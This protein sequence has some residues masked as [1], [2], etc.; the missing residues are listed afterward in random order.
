M[1]RLWVIFFVVTVLQA[2]QT[3]LSLIDKAYHSGKITKTEWLEYR[4]LVLLNPEKLP[5]EFKGEPEPCATDILVTHWRETGGK[6]LR[7]RPTLSGPEET[8]ETEHF[9]IHYTLSGDDATSTYYANSVSNYAEYCWS[10][11]VDSLGWDAPPS[12]Y[13]YGGDNRYDIYIINLPYGVLGYTQPEYAGPDPTQ[14]DM[15]SYI[16]I[17]NNIGSTGQLE[18]TVAHEFN[19]A[20][21]FSYSGNEDT[22]WMENCAVWMEDVVYDNVNDYIGYLE[23]SSPNPLASPRYAISTT[24]D[25]YEYA[26]GIWPMFLAEFY[27]T[28]DVPRK[29]WERMGTHVGD[30][31]FSDMDYVLNN[32]YSSNLKEALKY[33]ALW[34]YFTGSR[35]DDY[36][37]EEA[38]LW[39]T[40]HLLRYHNSYPASGDEGN[41]PPQSR[42]GTAYVDFN[43]GSGDL[44]IDFDGQDYYP[45]AWACFAVGYVSGGPSDEFEMTLDEDHAT[46][47]DTLSFADYDHITLI[48]VVKFWFSY[49][50]GLSFTYNADIDHGDINVFPQP[51]DVYNTD[52]GYFYVSNEGNGMLNVTDIYPAINWITG[53]DPSSFSL[54]PGDTQLVTFTMDTTGLDTLNYGYIVIASD[55][56]D[57]SNIL[58]T[59]VLHLTPY[60][61]GDIN[62]DGQITSGDLTYLSSYLFAGGPPP[63]SEWAADVNGDGSIT[64]GD[65]NYLAN[66]LFAGGPEPNCP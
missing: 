36:H 48:P 37:Y 28:V 50:S 29:M 52:T 44:H 6:I 1:K 54:S 66:Y 13:G 30:F 62:G 63:V 22:W 59:V 17:D 3:S 9:I 64:S 58:L 49:A 19:H 39:P 33:Y 51:V 53:V 20:C 35:A 27:D 31:T 60:I 10:V 15:T 7:Y 24:D 23:Y 11:E 45:D 18:V 61:C 42:G 47:S 21:Q 8:I 16:A 43:P 14:E 2:G 32:Y 40:S 12:D 38:S 46:G 55:D 56:P 5:N 34:R 26:G 41:S 65:L 4:K 25:L 57:E